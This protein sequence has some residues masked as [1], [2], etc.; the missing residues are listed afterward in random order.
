M[1]SVT[2]WPPSM[3][4]CEVL[5]VLEGTSPPG[6]I[7]WS[8][9]TVDDRRLHVLN[10]VNFMLLPALNLGL[11]DA[12]RVPR[13]KPGP[14]IPLFPSVQEARVP[15]TGGA[16]QF[17]EA[18]LMDA[19]DPSPHEAAHD[20]ERPGQGKVLRGYFRVSWRYRLR[21]RISPAVRGLFIVPNIQLN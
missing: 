18:H 8:T 10:N 19:P 2:S 9:P 4:E 5:A 1:C 13:R 7:V 11:G 3:A 16:G 14:P 6:W 17:A 12:H 15:L 20:A 21:S